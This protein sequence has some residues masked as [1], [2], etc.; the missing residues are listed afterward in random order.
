MDWPE[1]RSWEVTSVSTTV[2]AAREHLPHRGTRFRHVP[3]WLAV[4]LLIVGLGSGAFVG[5]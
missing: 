3:V 4:V 1:G 2:M 5:R